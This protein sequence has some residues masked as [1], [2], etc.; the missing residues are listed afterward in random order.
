MHNVTSE[1]F[2][3]LHYSLENGWRGSVSQTLD[4][5]KSSSSHWLVSSDHTHAELLPLQQFWKN[6]PVVKCG[7]IMQTFLWKE[8]KNSSQ[9]EEKCIFLPP[10]VFSKI[11]SQEFLCASNRCDAPHRGALFHNFNFTQ[12]NRSKVERDGCCVVTETMSAV[13]LHQKMCN[14]GDMT[15]LGLDMTEWPLNMPSRLDPTYEDAL[16]FPTW[17]KSKKQSKGNVPQRSPCQNPPLK[18]W[19][20]RLF[21][22]SVTHFGPCSGPQPPITSTISSF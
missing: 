22:V 19:L 20:Q 8:K 11:Q 3:L 5:P 7:K 17:Y 10:S 12:M 13:G 15:S 1:S 18:A 6:V 2:P 4:N 21:T 14:L 16:F 9:T